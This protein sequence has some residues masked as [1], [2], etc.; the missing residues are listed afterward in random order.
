MTE[1]VD[2]NEVEKFTKIADQ[3]WDKDGSLKTLHDIN[4]TR[5]KFIN[6]QITLK[7]KKVLDVGCGGGIL[8]ESLAQQGAC[9]SGIDMSETCIASARTHSQQQKLDIDYRCISIE[10]MA[11]KYAGQ[12]DVITCLE[13]LEHVPE[14]AA[15]IKAC[16]QLAKPGGHLFFST[17]NRTLK[18][19][20]SAIIAGEYILKMLPKQTHDYDKLIRP[21]ELAVWLRENNISLN[22]MTGLAYNPLTRTC[23]FRDDLSVNYM[24]YSV[25]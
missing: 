3:W 7:D 21:A 1:N 10:E 19:Y 5:M 23:H 2:P 22:K 20:M 6:E 17:I 8:T 25:K 14:P 4:P 13:L 16:G 18:A 24:I 15:V 12:F 11:E 9:A